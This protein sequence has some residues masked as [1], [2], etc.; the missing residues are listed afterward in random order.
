[1]LKAVKTVEIVDNE[2]NKTFYVSIFNRTLKFFEIFY[3]E[4][5]VTNLLKYIVTY[6]VSRK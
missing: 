4:E 2:Y 1:M 5:I 3:S 6:A